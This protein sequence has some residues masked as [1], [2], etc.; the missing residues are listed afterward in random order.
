MAVGLQQ[1]LSM[2]PVKGVRVA[3][4]ALGGRRQPRDDLALFELSSGAQ[5]AA[6]FTRNRF[7]AAPVSVARRHLGECA[8]RYFLVNAGNANAGTGER[9]LRDAERCCEMV[10]RAAGVPTVSVLPFST[11]VIGE[12][13]DLDRFDRAIPSAIE[14]LRPDAWVSAANA[15]MTTDTVVKGISQQFLIGGTQCRIN[16]VA[17]GSGMIRPD[18]ATMLAFAATD[19]AVGPE[20]LRAC[21]RAAADDSFN[22]ITVDGDTSTNDALVLAATGASGARRIDDP[23][24][25]DYAELFEAVRGAFQWL[26]Q[27]LI[28][29]AEGATK[30]ITV[31][32]EEGR[33]E[34]L[35]RTVAYAVAESPLVKTAMFASDPNWGRIL[36]AVGRSLP[37]DAEIE[38]V[39]VYLDDVCIVEGGGRS[40]G[41]REEDAQRVMNRDELCVRIRLGCGTHQA[42]IWTSDLSHEYVTINAEYRT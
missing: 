19:A 31:L 27:A 37:E 16:A 17:K 32:V 13:L 26:A 29:D 9:G 23:A 24:Q 33:S 25:N 2:M 1:E 14:G 22:C 40:Q 6:L 11:G 42:R 39:R 36:A 21:L 8:P 7:C 35:C 41:Y 3:S 15:I 5:C 34:A 30:F 10:A 12:H 20:A 18:M 28:R 4:A 38:R